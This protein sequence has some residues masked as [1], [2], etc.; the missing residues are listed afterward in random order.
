MPAKPKASPSSAAQPIT[1][2]EA[3]VA[4]LEIIVAHRRNMFRDMGTE[5]ALLEKIARNSRPFIERGLREGWYHGWLAAAS[6]EIAAG[7]GVMVY[8]WPTGPLDPDATKR[9]YFL[10]V[11]TEPKFR[12]RGLARKLTDV[13]IEWTRKQGFKVLWLHAS[14][15]GRPIYENLGFEQTNEMRITL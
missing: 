3:T 9:A 4:D 13:A 8:G 14:D 11:F 2:R 1:I 12:Q 6:G 5:P 10:N 7:A 15:Q